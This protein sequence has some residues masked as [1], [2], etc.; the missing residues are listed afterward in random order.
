MNCKSVQEGEEGSTNGAK[1]MSNDADVVIRNVGD[2]PVDVLINICSF[3]GVNQYRFVGGVCRN[4]EKAYGT[5][6]PLKTTCYN[7]STFKLAKFCFEEST[8][9]EWMSMELEGLSS[10]RFPWRRAHADMGSSQWMSLG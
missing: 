5:K 2:L 4:F 7:L 8:A 9:E 10:G 3:I 6:Y 1:K